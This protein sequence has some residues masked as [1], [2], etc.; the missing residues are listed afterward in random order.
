M[1]SRNVRNGLV[2]QRA[3]DFV[4]MIVREIRTNHDD[5]FR[6]TPQSTQH[7]TRLLWRGVA[8]VQRHNSEVWAEHGL[9]ERNLHFYRMFLCVG[10]A[11]DDH[12][13][14]RRART[15]MCTGAQWLIDRQAQSLTLGCNVYRHSA[16]RRFKRRCRGTGDA[17]HGHTVS[18]SHDYR[19]S[20]TPPP[21][22]EQSIGKRGRRAG[23]HITGMRHD[24]SLWHSR[25]KRGLQL[26]QNLSTV[27][28][29]MGNELLERCAVSGVERTSH[30]W[31]TYCASDF[32]AAVCRACCI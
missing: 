16:Q 28:Q 21:S 26:L 6:A 14:S 10:W 30:R 11:I 5:S 9:Q 8:R 24:Y 25:W 7:I 22:F 32:A 2:I 1:Q 3:G 4:R 13:G 15:G 19:A 29:L 12:C 27:I 17:S 18:R 20:H 23:I 31:R